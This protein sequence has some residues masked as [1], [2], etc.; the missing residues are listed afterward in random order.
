MAGKLR[1]RMLLEAKTDARDAYGAIAETWAAFPV[2]TTGK[3]WGDIA[4]EGG[5]ESVHAERNDAV[6]THTIQRRYVKNVTAGMRVTWDSRTF[7]IVTV[8]NTDNRNRELFLSC[9]EVAS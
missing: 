3:F 7:H 1:F 9:L 6:L 5:T 4:T 2:G 8:N